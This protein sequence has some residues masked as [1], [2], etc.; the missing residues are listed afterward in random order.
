MSHYEDFKNKLQLETTQ[1]SVDSYRDDAKTSLDATAGLIAESFEILQS[2][3]K[4]IYSTEDMSIA[5]NDPKV[6]D[7]TYLRLTTLQATEQTSKARETGSSEFL[8]ALIPND[9]IFQNEQASQFGETLTSKCE[10]VSTPILI[11]DETSTTHNA[12]ILQPSE[13]DLNLTRPQA[14]ESPFIDDT[15]RRA[16]QQ[17]EP[18]MIEANALSQIETNVSLDLAGRRKLENSRRYRERKRNREQNTIDENDRLRT[19]NNQLKEEINRVKSLKEKVIET[20]REYYEPDQFH[21]M[22]KEYEKTKQQST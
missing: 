1:L 5:F 7:L 11:S 13:A 22:M 10:N 16:I 18:L 21:F 12:Q 14:I 15:S 2:R 6:D 17:A 19:E 4:T 20:M 3:E 8:Y 9:L